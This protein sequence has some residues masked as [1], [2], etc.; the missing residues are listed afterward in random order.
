MLSDNL[1]KEFQQGWLQGVALGTIAPTPEN[2]KNSLLN[3][4]QNISLKYA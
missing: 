1:R 2:L 3:P 4:P